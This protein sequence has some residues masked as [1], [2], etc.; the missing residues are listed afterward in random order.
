[1]DSTVLKGFSL[2]EVLASSER[3]RGVSEL[4]RE[5]RLTKSNVQRLLTTLVELGYVERNPVTSQYSA[6]LKMW[7]FGHRVLSRDEIK[8]AA[9]AQMR[10]IYGDIN[11]TV[12]L[13]VG[14]GYDELYIDVIAHPDPMRMPCNVGGRW[15]Q[16]RT[17]SGKAMLA[18]RTAE[19]LEQA[20]DLMQRA[21]PA[22]VDRDAWRAEF[23]RIRSAGFA[24]SE[25]GFL[26]GINGVAAP[27]RDSRGNV[28]AALALTGPAERLAADRLG[29]H[30]LRLV[31]GAL[32]VSQALGFAG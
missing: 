29:S 6:T 16:W 32:R 25:G 19:A 17:V 12:L 7:E 13:S 3:P 23:E 14:S 27:I 30:A 22:P 21:N 28:V 18:H 11:E 24:V 20:L 26:A 8:R 5:M 15:P 4:S 9:M 10:S 1:M 31:H 2:I